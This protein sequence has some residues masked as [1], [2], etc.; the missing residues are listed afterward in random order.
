MTAIP[1]DARN[2]A[3]DFAAAIKEL[4]DAVA[5]IAYATDAVAGAR[6]IAHLNAAMRH[7]GEDD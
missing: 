2:P 3:P 7:I 5:V 4:A 1:P 6:A